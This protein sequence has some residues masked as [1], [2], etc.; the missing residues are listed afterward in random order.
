M[1]TVDLLRQDQTHLDY[2]DDQIIPFKVGET[3]VRGRVVRLGPAID[4]I[5]KAHRFPDGPSELVGEM[6]CLVAAMGASLKFDGKLILQAQ[7]KGPV[8]MVVAD[9]TADGALRATA[10]IHEGAHDKSGLG[11][12]LGEGHMVVT[13]DQG[14]DMERYQGVTP[15]EG[16][17]LEKAAVGYFMQSEQI[18]TVVRLAV[19]RMSRPG[20]GEVWRAGAIMAQFVPA[21]GGDRE[22]GEEILRL[23]DDQEVW[24]RAEAFV[25][26]TQ[27][28]ELL[29]PSLAPE[30]L[31]YRLFHEDGVRVFDRKSVRAHCPCHAGKVE[32]VLSRYGEEELSDMAEDGVIRVECEFCRTSYFFGPDGRALPQ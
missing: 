22:R 1:E 18:P 5:L 21:E 2:G 8:P 7:G 17:T 9:Y 11:S 12:L 27:A 15:V 23:E 14:P 16:D 13:I 24:D 25:Q 31:L 3:S 32:A 6:A 28:D 4:E 10:S 19:G 29:D 26:S 30:Q 20:E